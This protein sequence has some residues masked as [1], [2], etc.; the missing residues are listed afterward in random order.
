MLGRIVPVFFLKIIKFPFFSE[1]FKCQN[2]GPAPIWSP[3]NLVLQIW[4]F[5]GFGD[6]F[7]SGGKKFFRS[8]STGGLLRFQIR[9]RLPKKKFWSDVELPGTP[10]SH[11][12]GPSRPHPPCTHSSG[13]R[14]P[15][16]AYPL[17]HTVGKMCGRSWGGRT[18]SPR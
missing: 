7:F 10:L 11:T 13:P 15:A 8:S 14:T 12:H 4:E 2:F 9:R 18:L 16:L 3:A 1:V 5:G 17:L 6:F